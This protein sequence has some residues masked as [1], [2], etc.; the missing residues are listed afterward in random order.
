MKRVFLYWCVLLSGLLWTGC[1]TDVEICYDVHPHRTLLD[2]RFLWDEK[3]T[4]L[5][6]KSMHVVAIRLSNSIRYDYRVTS[7]NSS[8]KGI[9]LSPK[10]EQVRDTLYDEEGNKYSAKLEID[11]EQNSKKDN[12]VNQIFNKEYGSYIITFI[13]A[14]FST[15]ENAYYSFFIYYGLE[16]FN[17]I[18]EIKEKFS[19]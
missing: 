18:S 4:L 2:F 10:A 1:S 9:L 17:S 11:L 14:D 19:L 3:D 13:N 15:V 7:H 8:N 6:P 16:G 5:K 12:L